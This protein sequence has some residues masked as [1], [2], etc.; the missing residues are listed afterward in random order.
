[1]ICRKAGTML[2]V[3]GYFQVSSWY[4]TLVA[5]NSGA[6][7]HMALFNSIHGLHP[8]LASLTRP[9]NSFFSDSRCLAASR[10]F[11]FPSPSSDGNAFSPAGQLKNNTQTMVQQL[12]E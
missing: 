4:I 1:M 2:K 5:S 7:V 9:N 6:S 10:L 11:S 12:I 3:S 8:L